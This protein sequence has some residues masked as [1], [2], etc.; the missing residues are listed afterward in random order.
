MGMCGN[1]TEL[2]QVAMNK[3]QDV[4]RIPYPRTQ[5]ESTNEI[6]KIRKSNKCIKEPN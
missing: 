5:T 1:Y 3:I 6:A 4:F 2:W